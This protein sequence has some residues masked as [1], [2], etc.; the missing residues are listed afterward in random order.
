MHKRLMKAINR[1]DSGNVWFVVYLN[2]NCEERTMHILAKSHKEAQ[3]K[4]IKALN[5]LGLDKSA[6]LHLSCL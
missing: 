3:K 5:E 6:L 1:L 4:A 2:M